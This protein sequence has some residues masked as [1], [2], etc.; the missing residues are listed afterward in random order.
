MHFLF[1]GNAGIQPEFHV[2]LSC[3]C[4]SCSVLSFCVTAAAS[5]EGSVNDNDIIRTWTA[6]VS[7]TSC[8][9]KFKSNR[10]RTV[11]SMHASCVI[12]FRRLKWRMAQA[13]RFQPRLLWWNFKHS[14]HITTHM[15][16]VPAATG[17]ACI[18]CA[19]AT[20]IGNS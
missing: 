3:K 10:T 6:H 13:G 11:P 17:G 12:P 8:T 19:T 4:S 1:T 14:L 16:Q 15:K 18:F 9:H 20:P 2:N 7:H 5:P